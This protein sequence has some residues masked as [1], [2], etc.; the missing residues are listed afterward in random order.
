MIEDI[1]VF[2]DGR[3]PPKCYENFIDEVF[4]QTSQKMFKD[5]L[6]NYIFSDE[7]KSFLDEWNLSFV[8]YRLNLGEV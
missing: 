3:Q 7:Y 1:V 4:E 5:D 6:R 8:T 2:K